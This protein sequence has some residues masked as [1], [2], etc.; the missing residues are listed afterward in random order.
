ME[1]APL[2]WRGRVEAVGFWFPPGHPREQS[3]PRLLAELWLE[4]SRLLH[5][6]DGVLLLF[7][8]S[9]LVDAERGAGLPV[10][11]LGEGWATF[12]SA[13]PGPAKL[14]LRWRGAL[15]SAGLEELMPYE[16]AGLWNSLELDFREGFPLS[17]PLSR[18]RLANPETN[19]S[20]REI[21]GAVPAPAP[22]RE[23]WLRRL[24]EPT[25]SPAKATGLLGFFDLLRSV[26]GS[27]P[28]NQRYLVKM[29]DLFEKEHWD[30]A[31]RHAIPL[32]RSSLS[33]GALERFVGQLRPRRDLS[34]TARTSQGRPALGTSLEGIDLLRSVY[35]RAFQAMLQAGRIDEAA[36]VKGELLDDARGAVELLEQ[37]RRFEAAARL[38]TLKA[39]PAELQVR[40]WFLAGQVEK[41]MVLAR[42]FGVHAQALVHLEA[43]DREKARDFRVA[44]A[45]DLRRLGQTAEALSVAWEVR[46]RIPEFAAW[47]ENELLQ[48]GAG[49]AG[50]LALAV[51]DDEL[52]RDLGL[53]GRL[54]DWF[55]DQ[56]LLTLERRRTVLRLLSEQPRRS[57][58]PE[59]QRWAAATA[60]RVMRQANGPFP[61]A[62]QK[63]FE[64]LL[65]LSADPWLRADRPRTLPGQQAKLDSWRERVERRGQ[66]P[67]YDAAALGDGRCLL[68]LGYAGLVVVSSGGRIAQR[69][70]VPA[71]RLVV[72]RQGNL[73]LA[74][75]HQRISAFQQGRVNAWC[76]AELDDFADL[77]L[78]FD[79]F[80]WRQRELF[81]ID[82][83]PALEGRADW[84]AIEAIPLPSEPLRVAVGPAQVAV[85]FEDQ[86]NYH[87]HHF[88][89]VYTKHRLAGEGRYLLS[90]RTCEPLQ[91]WEGRVRFRGATLGGEGELVH[92]DYQDPYGV[93][94]FQAE[95]GLTLCLFDAEKAKRQLVLE[96]PEARFARARIRAEQAVICDDTGR[97]LLV[98]LASRKWIAQMFL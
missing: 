91:L 41:A 8:R 3:L 95:R 46:E 31:L 34:F 36:F 75:S 47:M 68:A 87:H 53:A 49:A 50:A 26:F 57:S 89:K 5:A 59:L 17:S 7:P 84:T 12:P 29:I 81:R 18:P 38:A 10:V 98:D 85:L 20:V 39:L 74:V 93:A 28:E 56:S 70:A 4:E 88:L 90:P 13:E 55:A 67:I 23:E 79:W 58:L 65:E 30:Q 14:V 73:Y 35:H 92:T 6:Y 11:A 15:W 33:S 21:L 71:H 43:R 52:C 32:D 77:H 61:L 82:L 97:L 86:V 83:I 45:W 24:R 44:W 1:G 80:V 22:E 62:D 72:P 40:L 94:I 54:E 78:G 66:L 16:L 64:T 96:L 63:A 27:A 19:E 2:R 60:R 69:F 25:E 51:G 76:S 48:D 37:H 9:Q 42:R